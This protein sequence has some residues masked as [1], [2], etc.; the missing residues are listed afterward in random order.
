MSSVTFYKKNM[1]LIYT[2]IVQP[3]LCQ[4]DGS[5]VAGVDRF[6]WHNSILPIVERLGFEFGFGV[7]VRIRVYRLAECCRN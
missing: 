5:T 1:L 7:D 4:S 3:P 2:E 6:P